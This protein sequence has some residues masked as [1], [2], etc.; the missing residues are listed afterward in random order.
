MN[1]IRKA[2]EISNCCLFLLTEDAK[3]TL[4]IMGE[5]KAYII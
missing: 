4:H 3:W 5:E 1:E 2:K